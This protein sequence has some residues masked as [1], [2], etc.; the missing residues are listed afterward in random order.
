M[1][2]FVFKWTILFHSTH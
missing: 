1:I 2:I